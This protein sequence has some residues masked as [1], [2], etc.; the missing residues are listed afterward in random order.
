GGYACPGTFR[1]ATRWTETGIRSFCQ[2]FPLGRFHEAGSC[3]QSRRLEHEEYRVPPYEA[4]R[5][6]RPR[7]CD[8]TATA[9]RSR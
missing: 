1:P 5:E 4:S 2:A 6:V 7:V 9:T 8:A 3:P